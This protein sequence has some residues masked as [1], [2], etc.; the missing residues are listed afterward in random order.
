VAEEDTEFFHKGEGSIP[1][2][3]GWS[4]YTAEFAKNQ[5][6]IHILCDHAAKEQMQEMMEM[7]ETYVGLAM[8]AGRPQVYKNCGGTARIGLQQF[9]NF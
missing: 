5:R 6:V 8:A 4:N 1:T 2:A 7:L 3:G 9:L